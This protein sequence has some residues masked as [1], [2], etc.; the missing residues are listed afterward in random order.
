MKISRKDGWIWKDEQFAKGLGLGKCE[1]YTK[2]NT[3][4]LWSPFGRYL[5][6]KVIGRLVISRDT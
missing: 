4:Y 2:K 3:N 1:K 5:V 6:T